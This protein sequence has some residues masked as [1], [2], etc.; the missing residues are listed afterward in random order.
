MTT[1]VIRDVPESVRN[2]LAARAARSGRSMQQYVLQTLQDLVARPAQ[3]DVLNEIRKR[4]GMLPA[5]ERKSL[6]DDLRAEQR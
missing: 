4:A 3:E 1:V 6:L 5:L 2:E